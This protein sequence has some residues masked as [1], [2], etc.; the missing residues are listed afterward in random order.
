[1]GGATSTIKPIETPVVDPVASARKAEHA[2][3]K[4]TFLQHLSH[5]TSS[6]SID[7]TENNVD[8]PDGKHKYKFK[9]G[10]LYFGDWQDG[11][12]Q[13]RG[14]LNISNSGVIYEGDF[15]ANEFHGK[16]TFICKNG[17]IYK[18]DFVM[19]YKHGQGKV[20]MADGSSMKGVWAHGK[21]LGGGV[22][23]ERGTTKTITFNGD[24]FKYKVSK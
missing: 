3:R 5:S 20:D 15:V 22:D 12:M 6:S 17:N 21:K 23:C 14:T 18:G 1:M 19:G 11:M 8:L 24:L 10:D 13:G 16:G 7:S 4:A 9:N 2:A